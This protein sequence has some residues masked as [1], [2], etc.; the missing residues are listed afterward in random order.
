MGNYTDIFSK[1]GFDSKHMNTLRSWAR[2]FDMW[3]HTKT[4]MQRKLGRIKKIWQLYWNW[5]YERRFDFVGDILR[6]LMVLTI[7]FSIMAVATPGLLLVFFFFEWL[8]PVLVLPVLILFGWAIG[9][10]I[11]PC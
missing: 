1:K 11:R 6:G 9:S 10:L 5:Y 4:I 2:S 3:L 8:W 7:V